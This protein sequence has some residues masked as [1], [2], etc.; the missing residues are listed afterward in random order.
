MLGYAGRQFFVGAWMALKNHTATM[1]T[2]VALGLAAAWSYS[3]A[4]TAMP[5]W[6]PPGT[7]E[8][9]WD[10]VAV[11]VGLVVLGQTLEMR[12]RPHF[13]GHQAAA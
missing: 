2:L 6:S 13:A 1:D 3:F 10:V 4:V 8:P 11:I 5:Q 12:A 7:A 9:Y